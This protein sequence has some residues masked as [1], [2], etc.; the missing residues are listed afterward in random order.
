VVFLAGHLL[1]EDEL[2]RAQVER[3]ATS[4]RHLAF[5]PGSDG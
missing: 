3:Y 5:L 2:L 4:L 1:Q